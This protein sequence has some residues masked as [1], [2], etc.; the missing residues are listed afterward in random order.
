M[1]RVQNYLAAKRAYAKIVTAV[2]KIND[3]VL[4]IIFEN[5]SK[6]V[7]TKVI[8]HFYLKKKYQILVGR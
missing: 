6:N 2:L 4:R 8:D 7:H 5:R 1:R 3:T